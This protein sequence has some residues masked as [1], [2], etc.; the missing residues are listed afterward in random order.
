M[1]A[2]W[3]WSVT[4]AL[5]GGLAALLLFAPAHWVASAVSQA[6]QGRLLLSQTRGTLWDGSAQLTLTAGAGSQDA[7]RLPGRLHWQLGLR[8]GHAALQLHADCCTPQPTQVQITPRWGSLRI[9]IGSHQSH[10]PAQLLAGLGTPW[11]TL[12]P[13]GQLA[14][15]SP[16]LT[17]QLT[18]SHLHI[19][20]QLQL[21]AADLSSRL[22]ALHPMGSYQL[23]LQGGPTP[24]LQLSTTRGDLRLTGQGQWVGARLRFQGEASAAP[25]REDALNNLLNIIGRRDGARSLITL[26]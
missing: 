8:W 26:G 15:T 12:Q 16:A 6:T 7:T 10:W 22:S 3:P 13:Q 5:T 4:G 18:P 1:Q 21:N 2:L 9:A 19:E 11:N 17:L 23:S 25:G 14:V 20:G 24:S